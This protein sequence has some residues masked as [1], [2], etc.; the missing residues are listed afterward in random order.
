[1]LSAYQLATENPATA[2]QGLPAGLLSLKGLHVQTTIEDLRLAAGKPIPFHG[3]GFVLSGSAAHISNS[4]APARPPVAPLRPAP[5]VASVRPS[6]TAIPPQPTYRTA[7]PALPSA[8]A[9][10][11]AMNA[12]AGRPG[13]KPVPAS[14]TGGKSLADLANLIYKGK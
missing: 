1:M 14:P 12:P 5:V 2:R 4:A 10:Y 13:S 9:I 6:P 3:D 8:S 11:A 7:E